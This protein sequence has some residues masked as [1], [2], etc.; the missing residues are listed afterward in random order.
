MA[1]VRLEDFMKPKSHEHLIRDLENASNSIGDEVFEYWTQNRNLSVSL[2]VMAQP[3]VVGQLR[4]A[5]PH[6]TDPGDASGSE[7]LLH[8]P[9]MAAEFG[10]DARHP[11]ALCRYRYRSQSGSASW[12]ISATGCRLAIGCRRVERVAQSLFAALELR[13]RSSGLTPRSST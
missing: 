4:L 1:G 6:P 12:G 8:G 5:P 3:V 7:G 13:A 2:D 11:D 9:G 10:G